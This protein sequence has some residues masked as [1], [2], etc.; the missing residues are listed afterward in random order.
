[1]SIFLFLEAYVFLDY[2]FMAKENNSREVS[3]YI[4]FVY[5]GVHNVGFI[6][7]LYLLLIVGMHDLLL[8]L[9]V[10]IKSSSFL[11]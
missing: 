7:T 8:L 4:N 9:S 10:S 2:L 5:S 11:K 3:V 6:T 1:M